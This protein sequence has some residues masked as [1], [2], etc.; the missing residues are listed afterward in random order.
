[1][2][3]REIAEFLMQYTDGELPPGQRAAFKTHLSLCWE[4]REYLQ[5]YELTVRL[6]RLAKSH[7]DE[8]VPASVPNELVRAILASRPHNP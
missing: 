1:M 3:C 7:D 5:S 2:T 4:C 8:P 6:A